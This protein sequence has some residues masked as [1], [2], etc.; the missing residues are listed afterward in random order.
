M[1]LTFAAE[2]TGQAFRELLQAFVG[3]AGSFGVVLDD[4][5]P[6]A[7][8]QALL[9]ALSDKALSEEA[10]RTWPGVDVP[11]WAD[12]SVVYTF[13]YDAAVPEIL[14]AHC[15]G[16]FAWQQC[17]LPCDLHLRALDGSVLLG[18]VT[19]EEDAWVELSLSEWRA[20][21]DEAQE[22]RHLPIRE[23]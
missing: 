13:S 17:R 10:T 21:V 5:S 11:E 8:T 23:D 15:P 3:R 4:V 2:P 9:A 12:S 6:R 14:F 16:L 7:E 20:L 1:T 22:L 19:A 18:S